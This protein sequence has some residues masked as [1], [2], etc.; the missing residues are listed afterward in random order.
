MSIQKTEREKLPGE[1]RIK[2]P[3]E[4]KTQPSSTMIFNVS[5]G[6]LEA[7]QAKA[8]E[9]SNEA[10]TWLASV[11]TDGLRAA[12]LRKEVVIFFDNFPASDESKRVIESNLTSRMAGKDAELKFDYGMAG[13]IWF[14][15]EVPESLD[16]ESHDRPVR[17]ALVPPGNEA[18]DSVSPKPRHVFGILCL[19][20]MY[21]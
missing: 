21:S 20:Q 15:V 12:C 6:E 18:Y 13:S 10:N 2:L 17:V 19:K 11:D 9:L 3:G 5:N 14:D 8:K 16:E 7:L 1:F 4:A